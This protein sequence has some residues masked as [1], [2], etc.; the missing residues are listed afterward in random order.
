[1]ARSTIIYYW[2]L[3]RSHTAL[4]LRPIC[5]Y[6]YVCSIVLSWKYRGPDV[7]IVTASQIIIDCDAIYALVRFVQKNVIWLYCIPII[8]GATFMGFNLEVLLLEKF[9]I[10]FNNFVTVQKFGMRN[11]LAKRTPVEGSTFQILLTSPNQT[12]STCSDQCQCSKCFEPEID[13]FREI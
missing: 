12:G 8:N 7:S 10:F 4:E 2:D 11:L 9:E 5:V 1:M 6:N 3:G 13:Q